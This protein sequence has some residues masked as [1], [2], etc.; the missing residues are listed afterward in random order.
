MSKTVKVGM[1][2]TGFVGD[3]HHAAFQGWVH[4]AEVVAVSSPHS[5]SKFAEERGIAQSYSDYHEM[6]KDKEI[7]VIDIG[8]PNDLHCQVVVDAARA[9][10]H[11]IIEKPLCV[12]LEE[13]DEMIEECK[14]AGV[15]LMYAEELLFAPKYVRAKKL[16]DEGAIGERSWPSSLR[17]TRGRIWVG[18]GMETVQVEA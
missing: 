1:V 11:V 10:K 8:I 7:D 17:S 2:G 3:L 15:L 9:G 13:A 14:K 5:A 16:I 6:L 4:N 12:T 18:S